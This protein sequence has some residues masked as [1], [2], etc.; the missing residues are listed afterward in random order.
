MELAAVHTTHSMGFAYC[1]CSGSSSSPGGGGGGGGRG[2]GEQQGQQ[3][4]AKGRACLALPRPWAAILRHHQQPRRPPTAAAPAATEA[5]AAAT[6]AAAALVDSG[7]VGHQA[8][9]TA[10][11]SDS[12]SG[13]SF[14]PYCGSL[15][16]GLGTGLPLPTDDAGVF[17]AA[18]AWRWPS[19]TSM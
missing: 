19:A 6:E 15:E 14:L 7:S 1:C 9:A 11:D 12:D 3:G 16:V 18:A 17:C 4:Q 8:V 2:G 10:V 5:A 13:S